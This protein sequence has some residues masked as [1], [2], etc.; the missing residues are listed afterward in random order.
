MKLLKVWSLAYTAFSP[1]DSFREN[2]QMHRCGLF[3]SIRAGLYKQTCYFFL[4][5]DVR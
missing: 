4:Y 5:L 1:N 3:W 2:Q